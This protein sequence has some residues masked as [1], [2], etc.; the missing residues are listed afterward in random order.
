[1]FQV[2]MQSFQTP[3]YMI[4]MH[5][6]PVVQYSSTELKLTLSNPHSPIL[7][8]SVLK[9]MVVEQYSSKVKMQISSNPTSQITML[10]AIPMLKVEQCTSQEP[11]RKWLTPNSPMPTPTYRVVQ[12]M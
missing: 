11:M 2:T 10:T 4:Q 8:H 6:I 12:Y 5:H 3:P 1:M 7:T 9:E